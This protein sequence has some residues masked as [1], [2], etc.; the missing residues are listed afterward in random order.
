MSFCTAPV[1]IANLLVVIAAF[2][3]MFA[4]KEVEVI[5]SRLAAIEVQQRVH[6]QMLQTVLQS[7]AKRDGLE[8]CEL[9]EDVTLPLENLEDLKKLERKLQ[10]SME[11]KTL[12]V[13]SY[14]AMVVSC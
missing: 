2:Y 14:T 8:S 12:M 13:S 4:G 3:K 7:A 6:T 9:P 11:T 10:E 5:L 1:A